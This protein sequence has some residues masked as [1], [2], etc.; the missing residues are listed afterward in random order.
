[1]VIRRAL[2]SDKAKVLEFCKN[3][4]EWGD[5]IETVW[6]E[7]KND[8]SGILL[9]KEYKESTESESIPIGVAHLG[10]CINN[11]MWIEGIRVQKNF[12]NQGIASSLL[13]H[14]INHGLSKGYR[15][16]SALVAKNN[17]ISQKLLE[18]HNFVKLFM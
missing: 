15:E 13:Q 12:R 7:W 16:A 14:M 4:F 3:T 6:D 17:I 11:V 8:L 9:V 5:Y 2:D 1:M 18:K 10:F